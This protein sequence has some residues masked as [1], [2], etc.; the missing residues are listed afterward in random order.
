MKVIRKIVLSAF[1]AAT[2]L[3]GAGAAAAAVGTAAAPAAMAH[4]TAVEY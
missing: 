2:L 3:G 1:I 4:P